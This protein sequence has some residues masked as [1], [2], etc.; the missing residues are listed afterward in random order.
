MNLQEL[1]EEEKRLSELLSDNRQKQ[2]EIN[3]DI[4]LS[5]YGVKIGD[6]IEFKDGKETIT[7]MLHRI[8]YNGTKVYYPY[9]MQLNSDGK[10]GKRE[11]R[12]WWSGFETIKLVKHT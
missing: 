11:K 4:F 2:R 5:K 12:C 10:A 6:I 1:E 8:E 9:V 7:G 3:T